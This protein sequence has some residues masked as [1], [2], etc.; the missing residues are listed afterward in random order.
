[1]WE[2]KKPTIQKAKLDFTSSE[3]GFCE[4]SQLVSDSIVLMNALELMEFDEGEVQVLICDRCGTTGCESGNWIS[5]RKSGDYILLIPA[6]EQMADDEWSKTEYSPPKYYKQKGT[7]FF[8]LQ[9]DKDLR[10]NFS[11]FPKIDEIKNLKM[12]E[13]MRLAQQNMPLRIFGEPPEI[14]VRHDKFKYI[15]AASEG[16]ADEQLKRLQE[17][18]S[19]NYQNNSFARIRRPSANEEIISLFTDINE[20]TDWQALIKTNSDYFLML[21]EEFLIEELN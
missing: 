8:D 13:A 18:L 17:I 2:I 4:V 3:Q 14:N 6:F 21:E 1:M 15:T 11:D 19:K 12:Q 20:F 10:D 5:F 16:T 7:P 9:N